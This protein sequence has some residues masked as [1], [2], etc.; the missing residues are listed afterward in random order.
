MSS[1]ITALRGALLDFHADPFVEG[2]EQAR[3][4]EADGIVAMQ[5][6][7]IIASGAAAD[8]L[9][10]LPPDTPVMLRPASARGT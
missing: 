3:R 1:G 6:G 4:Y 5:D 9:Q 8:V 10:R 2:I 7:R